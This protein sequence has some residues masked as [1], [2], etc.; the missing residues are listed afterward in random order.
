MNERSDITGEGEDVEEVLQELWPL[1]LQKEQL[2]KEE[3]ILA[4][5]T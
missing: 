3:E 1:Y 5:G 4:T 2:R